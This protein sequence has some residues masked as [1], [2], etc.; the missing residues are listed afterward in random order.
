MSAK[1]AVPRVA[2]SLA[3]LCAGGRAGSVEFCLEF[4]GAARIGSAVRA[5]GSCGLA[6]NLCGF[7]GSCLCRFCARGWVSVL[8]PVYMRR[9]CGWKCAHASVGAEDVGTLTVWLTCAQAPVR[10]VPRG[11][12]LG[13]YC[14]CL[15]L[16]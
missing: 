3:D 7:C 16:L 10:A 5:R 14:R 2:D 4:A 12:W 6:L 9:L 13:R 8:L 11:F 1:R 15:R